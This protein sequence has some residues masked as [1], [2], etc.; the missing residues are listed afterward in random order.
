M[1]NAT[2]SQQGLKVGGSDAKELFLKVWSG[3]VIS[4]FETQNTTM[5]K[6]TVHTISSGKSS[7][8]SNLRKSDS[9]IP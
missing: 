7:Y 6:H 8:F 4:A 9:F 5:D 2:V 1:S 3:E